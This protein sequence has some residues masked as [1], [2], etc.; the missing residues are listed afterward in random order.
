MWR[1]KTL[2]NISDRAHCPIIAI[3]GPTATGKTSISIE[4]AQAYQT[5]IISADSQLVYKDL[6]IGTAKPTLKERA[7]IIHH[8][9][10]CVSP[11][12]T[13]TV[14]QYTQTAQAILNTLNEPLKPL[15]ITGGTGFYLRALLEGI[16]LP[17]IPPNPEFRKALENKT[18]QE[19]YLQLQRLD[20]DRAV[21]LFENDRPRIIR[22]LEI[23]AATG[24]PVPQVTEIPN[25]HPVLW[26]GLNYSD[27]N[28]HRKL[29]DQRI[30]GMLSA[31][32][33]AE[34]EQLM[35][36]YGTEAH[37]LTVAH[38]YPEWIRYIQGILAY[39]EALAQVQLNIHQYARRQRTWFRRNPAIHW[40]DRST[41]SPE[42][43]RRQINEQCQQWLD[44]RGM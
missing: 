34:V 23:I 35:A 40:Y 36:R 18:N 8:L 41:N 13:F 11:E 3:V 43:I 28:E 44:S 37:A 16:R 6:D 20:P 42:Q 15:I 22:A 29:I 27:R 5:E 38:G 1:L 19:L 9:I 30:E 25:P 2:S 4:L 24:K 32:W 33:L 31:G 21:S 7:G 14:E 26:I 39:N 10:D 12:E 17:G